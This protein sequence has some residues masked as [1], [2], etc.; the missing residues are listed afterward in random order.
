MEIRKYNFLMICTLLIS[1]IMFFSGCS[2]SGIK[3]NTKEAA[4]HSITETTEAVT[5]SVTEAAETV[6][7]GTTQAAE[8]VNS[9]YNL[10][11]EEIISAFRF[12][13]NKEAWINGSM[14]YVNE[15]KL[16][17]V[18]INEVNENEYYGYLY[19]ELKNKKKYKEYT[20]YFGEDGFQSEPF[21]ETTTKKY[22][23]I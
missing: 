6:T 1:F 23:K 11:K 12:W 16:V 15:R 9:D 10:K 18:Y 19:F 8:V 2:D 4:T 17:K 5:P 21:F 3:N 22:M 14:D 13:I 20:F 7:P